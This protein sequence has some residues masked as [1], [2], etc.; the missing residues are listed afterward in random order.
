VFLIGPPQGSQAHDSWGTTYTDK[1]HVIVLP[2]PNPTHM[3]Q[4]C[5]L[6][7]KYLSQRKTFLQSMHFVLGKDIV[8]VEWILAS[9]F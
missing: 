6:N 7:P 3:I 9:P 4:H 5:L 2:S 8:G 1:W